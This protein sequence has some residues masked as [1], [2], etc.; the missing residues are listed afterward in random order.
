MFKLILSTLFSSFFFFTNV[1]SSD[2][3]NLWLKNFKSKAVNKGISEEV[4]ND[5]MSDAKFLPKVIEYD[6]YQPEFYEDTFTY[7][8]KRSSNR[9]IKEGLKLYKKEKNLIETVEKDFQV[10][11]ELLLALM[12]IETNFGKYLGKM[13][14]V[15]SLATLS[16]DKRRSEFFTEELLILL[17][18]VDKKII[19][20]NILF[21]SW[22]GAFG[23]FQFMPRTIKD[24]A[25]DYNKN[26]TIE[27]KDIED[28]FASAANYLK[29]IG[30]KKNEPCFFRVDLNESIPNKYLNSSARK[31]KNKKNFKFLKKYIKNYDKL[32]IQDDL[33]AA[34]IIP[35]KDI[36]PGAKTLSPAYIVFENYEKI[37]S[38]NRS[39]RFALAVCTLK[40]SFKNE[41]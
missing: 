7:I 38:W 12:G 21:G 10:E 28:S 39:L 22:A 19:D 14:I 20:K 27:L 29:S 6:R 11:K 18:L 2:D 5:I 17:R 30:W 41:I 4:V 24:Y 9:K 13:D 34:I 3:F 23:N 31:I 25:I 32:D 35:D 40:E 37:L 36:I 15:S 26:K 16:Y 8:K 33:R 1:F